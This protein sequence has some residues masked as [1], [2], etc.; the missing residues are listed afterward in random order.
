[1]TH[2]G[3]ILPALL[4]PAL[5]ALG[6][7]GSDAEP[8]SAAEVTTADFCEQYAAVQEAG[9]FEKTKSAIADLDELGLPSEVSDDARAGFAT[10]AGIA[11]DAED[12]AEA[13]ELAGKVDRAGQEEVAEFISFATDACGGPTGQ[14]DDESP[15]EDG[16]EEQPSDD[17]SAE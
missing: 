2:V 11:S 13:S 4:L 15:S 3:R 6:A 14:G 17:P 5:A 8:E 12:N 9:D 1:M 16:G 10:L 7:C